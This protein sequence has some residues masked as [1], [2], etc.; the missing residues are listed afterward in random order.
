[1]KKNIIYIALL[2]MAVIS[3]CSKPDPDLDPI[4]IA[5]VTKGA[6]LTLRGAALDNLSETAYLGAVDT[7][8]KKSDISKETFDYAMDFLAEDPSTLAKVDIYA[9]AQDGGARGSKLLTIDASQ[10][11][12]VAGDKFPRAVISI[13]M[14]TVLASINKKVSDFASNT[15][16]Y[17]EADATLKDGTVI[18]PKQIVNSSLSETA[19]FYPA[20]KVPCV[21]KD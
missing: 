6:L 15:Y 17:V 9:T 4:Q 18:T 10:F 11:A 21:V 12:T 13:P 2:A 5:K 3:S 20:H 1:M 16:F 8:G 14:A 7:L 19:L